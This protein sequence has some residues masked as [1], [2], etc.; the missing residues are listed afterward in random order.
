VR[1]ALEFVWAM[2]MSLFVVAVVL[3]VVLGGITYLSPT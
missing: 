3:L 2:G 1:D